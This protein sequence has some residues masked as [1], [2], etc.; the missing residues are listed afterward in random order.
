METDVP[1]PYTRLR[2]NLVLISPCASPG[3]S[4]MTSCTR[5]SYFGTL[6][7]GVGIAVQDNAVS[8]WTGREGMRNRRG[9][10]CCRHATID[11]YDA[12]ASHHLELPVTVAF[13]MRAT[14]HCH[15]NRM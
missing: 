3:F 15:R 12:H 4:T 9:F 1:T 11:E 5:R 2:S 7:V 10:R 14:R 8:F 13:D 6:H